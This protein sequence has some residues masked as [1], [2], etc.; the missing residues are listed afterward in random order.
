MR[1]ANALC[2]FAIRVAY[3]LVSM[4]F[5]V[6]V[7]MCTYIESGRGTLISLLLR[8]V[9]TRYSICVYQHIVQYST[10]PHRTW[11]VVGLVDEVESKGFEA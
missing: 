6:S 5:Y 4:E 10:V 9:C 7:D 11:F 3:T 2:P 8:T 1:H